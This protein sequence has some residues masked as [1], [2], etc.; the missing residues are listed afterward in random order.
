MK[1]VLPPLGETGFSLSTESYPFLRN[2]DRSNRLS[3][4]EGDDDKLD[5]FEDQGNHKA[6]KEAD[7][8][9]HACP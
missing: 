6:H 3:D 9:F 2:I 8:E 4:P 7:L 1:K 5:D